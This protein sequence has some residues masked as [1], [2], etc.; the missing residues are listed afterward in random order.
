[1]IAADIID[2]PMGSLT[3]LL[4]AVRVSYGEAGVSQIMGKIEAAMSAGT[5]A[6]DS[7][8]IAESSLGELLERAREEKALIGNTEILEA[9]YRDGSSVICNKCGGLVKRERWMNHVEFWCEG[10]ERHNLNDDEDDDSFKDAR[11]DD[12]E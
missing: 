10:G 6:S 8:A 1:M 9:A 7:L 4:A 2:N 3:E 11:D 5:S 12:M